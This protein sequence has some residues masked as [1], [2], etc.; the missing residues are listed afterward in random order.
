MKDLDLIRKIA[1][2]F[3]TTTNIDIKDLIQEAS[4]AYLKAMQNYDPNRGKASVFVWYAMRNHLNN[5]IKDFQ[6]NYISFEDHKLDIAY[7]TNFLFESLSKEAQTIAELILSSPKPF[8]TTTPE[9]AKKRVEKV[10][11]K[12]GWDI[13]KI[14]IG[15]NDLKLAF[16]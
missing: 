8:I 16:S 5:Y 7:S 12:K 15:I 9:E 13:K 3:H 6:C 2:S 14:W 4:Y 1:W 11:V 10:L